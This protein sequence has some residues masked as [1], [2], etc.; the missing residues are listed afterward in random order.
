MMIGSFYVYDTPS[1]LKELLQSQFTRA[2]SSQDDFEYQFGLLYSSYSFPNLVLPFLG[3]TFVDKVGIP[4]ALILFSVLILVGQAIFTVGVQANQLWIMLLGRAVYGAGG[5]SM[6]VAQSAVIARWFGGQE[7]AF[8]LAVCVSVSRLGSVFN[9][10]AS[11]YLADHSGGVAF[12]LWFGAILC[13]ACMG[14]VFVLI[15][16]EKRYKEYIPAAA[17]AESGGQT[18]VDAEAQMDP[19]QSKAAAASAAGGDG[20]DANAGANTYSATGS[21]GKKKRG[22]IRAVV[23]SLE[24]YFLPFWLVT[25]W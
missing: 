4:T 17:D 24:G 22:V 8:A 25:A 7:L 16:V 23:Q 15:L 11:P 18:P 1:A 20:G 19:A 13:A 21:W 12:A 5:D 9:N 3:G 10:S 6:I 14:I 2:G